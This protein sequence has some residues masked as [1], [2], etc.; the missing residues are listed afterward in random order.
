MGDNSARAGQDGKLQKL[1]AKIESNQKLSGGRSVLIAVPAKRGGA[2]AAAAGAMSGSVRGVQRARA[3]SR[4]DVDGSASAG[5]VLKQ[6]GDGSDFVICVTTDDVRI[7][8]LVAFGVMPGT[9]CILEHSSIAG[10]TVDLATK[11]HLQ[12]DFHDG[13]A[14]PFQVVKDPHRA[15]LRAV[16][17]ATWPAVDD[18]T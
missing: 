10:I 9:P 8:R 7:I 17:A 3:R 11:K 13:S 2:L 1:A 6:I 15:S 4:S 5:D 12:I 16:A 14:L 18:P